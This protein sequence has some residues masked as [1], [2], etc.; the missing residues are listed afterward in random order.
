[1]ANVTIRDVARRADVHPS[2]VSLALRGSCKVS[3]TVRRRIAELAETMGY[4]P[5]YMASALAG[6]QT[7]TVG[8][9]ERSFSDENNGSWKL[10]YVMEPPLSGSVER[11]D[12]IIKLTDTLECQ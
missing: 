7:R 4:R 2:T 5:N 8:L 10:D 6:G 3:E 12:A 11:T 9:L 1:M